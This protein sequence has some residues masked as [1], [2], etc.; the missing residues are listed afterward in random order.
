MSET[1][2]Q[3]VSAAMERY[4]PLSWSALS[5]SQRAKEIYAEM[6]KIDAES[7]NGW[8]VIGSGRRASRGRQALSLTLGKVAYFLLWATVAL[9]LVGAPALVVLAL[10]G[11]WTAV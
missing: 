9:V 11:W 7:A 10:L 6:R 5:Q 2:E 1:F 4:D 3:A 8:L